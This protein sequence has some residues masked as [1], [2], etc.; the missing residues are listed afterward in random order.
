VQLVEAIEEVFGPNVDVPTALLSVL[1]NPIFFEDA[2]VINEE[3]RTA[4]QSELG[5]FETPIIIKHCN[6]AGFQYYDSTLLDQDSYVRIALN[7]AS[8]YFNEKGTPRFSDFLGF[9]TNSVF[10]L[11]NLWTQDYHTFEEEGSTLIGTPIY[12]RQFNALPRSYQFDDGTW[13]KTNT[14]ILPGVLQAPNLTFTASSI[15]ETATTGVHELTYFVNVD[16]NS[17][18]CFSFYAR[19]GLQR[20][21]IA[22]QVEGSFGVAR[23]NFNITQGSLGDSVGPITDY[24]METINSWRRC[25]IVFSSTVAETIEV[26]VRIATDSESFSYSGQTDAGIYGFGAQ[27]DKDYGLNQY[28]QTTG[29]AINIPGAWY[30][31]THVELVYDLD[32]F[33]NL[34][35]ENITEL[36]YYFAP[37]TLVLHRLK[38]V[39]KTLNTLYVDMY[40]REKI[41]DLASEPEEDVILMTMVALTKVYELGEV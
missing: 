8:Y 13:V 6:L 36:F 1:R 34:P 7:I 28:V 10:D 12:K 9:C 5:K 20:D 4:A 14:Y 11:Y 21:F 25:Y 32:K 15:K 33:G 35:G 29:S 37:I 30:P 17:V 39:A 24:N 23:G 16:A 38:L 26:K 41:I 18:Y 2:R 22:L 40:G 3:D 19:S 31:T 27:L